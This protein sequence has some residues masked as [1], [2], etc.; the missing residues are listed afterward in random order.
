MAFQ[1]RNVICDYSLG[2]PNQVNMKVYE[3][4]CTVPTLHIFGITEEGRKA[5][6]HV[7]GVLPYLF[8][9]VGGTF[10]PYIETLM[11]TKLNRLLQRELSEKN[12]KPG[13]SYN[14]N[15]VFKMEEVE[16]KS[17]YGYY[18]EPESYAKVYFTNPY[19][20]IK[21]SKALGK[22]LQA[23]P[24]LQPYESHIPYTL[25]FFIDYSLFG[26]DVIHF[27]KVLYRI[28]P[29]RLGSEV[30]HENLTAVEIRNSEALSP[31]APIT[32][33]WIECDAYASDI[34]NSQMYKTNKYS[35]NPGLEYLWSEEAVRC[36]LQNRE[37]KDTFNTYTPRPYF[38]TRQERELKKRMKDVARGLKKNLADS[39]S[40]STTSS[41]T[42]TQM[43]N[44]TVAP[45]MDMTFSE[46]MRAETLWSTQ[47]S[48]NLP[49]GEEDE[50]DILPKEDE[51]TEE[52]AEEEISDMTM[53]AALEDK[54]TANY[55]SQRSVRSILPEENENVQREWL[56]V[57]E[58]LPLKVK[59]EV[60]SQKSQSSDTISKTMTNKSIH[61][62]MLFSE[63]FLDRTSLETTQAPDVKVVSDGDIA[64]VAHFSVAS[65]EII[66]QSSHEYPNPFSDPIIGVSICVI[67]DV[68]RSL[69]SSEHV[70]ITTISPDLL[71]DDRCFWVEDEKQ[72]FEKV[73]EIIHKCDPEMLLGYDTDRLSWGYLLRRGEVIGI[74]G[75]IKKLARY[76][77][78]STSWKVNESDVTSPDGRIL[79]T[80]WKVVRWDLA[81]R[82]YDRC[83]AALEVLKTKV[84]N[85]A[86]N[87]LCE[88]VEQFDK[89]LTKFVV[90][91]LLR[92]SFVDIH[93]LSEMDWF[94]RNAEMARV[95][96]IQL[97]E[98]WNRGSQ[99]RVES[100]LLR[101]A[102]TLGYVAPAISP[103]Q[104]TQMSAPEQ[105]Q[106]ILEP[107]S[108]VYHDPV[109]VL[110]F[111]SLYPSMIIAYNYCFST[112]MGKVDHL[113]LSTS[114]SEKTLELGAMKYDVN[115]LTIVETVAS[116]QFRCSPLSASFVT[117]E[118]RDGLIP[119]MLREVLGARIMIKN[120]MKLAKSRRLRRILD[121]RQLALKLV[122]NVTYGYTAANWSGRMPCPELADAILGKGRETLER[123]IAQV[124]K[125]NY[126]TSQVIYGDTDSMFVLVPGGTLEEAFEIGR[127]IAADVTNANPC[128]VT[129][130]LEKVYMGCVLETKKRYAGWMFESET[131][132]GRLDSKGIETIR[133]D[134]CPIVSKILSKSLELI[135]Q[136]RW[137]SLNIYLDSK[138]SRLDDL[139]FHNFTFSKE[140]RG[141]Y[142]LG[143][144][145]PQKKIAEALLEKNPV[146]VTL[147]GER[148]SYVIVEG[149]PDATVISC[150]RSLT[151]FLDNP[152]LKIHVS[153][154]VRAHI[155]A[156]L[157][158][159][160]D[161]IPLQIIWHQNKPRHCYTPECWTIGRRPWCT[162]C[163][164]QAYPY[165][166]AQLSVGRNER[167]LSIA[168]V[169]C[170]SCNQLGPG[171]KWKIES[172]TNFHCPVRQVIA[173]VARSEASNTLAQHSFSKQSRQ[174]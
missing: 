127:R 68:C 15:F 167:L 55:L 166:Y 162:S 140:Y 148:V 85:F 171:H 138:L 168:Q 62:K 2:P 3:S 7:H 41:G 107:V 63:S 135:F 161:L 33:C 48:P 8:L 89:R 60:P 58:D 133:R 49:I 93:I 125:G 106:L 147:P 116:R 99:F 25:Q 61:N 119:I 46:D 4:N 92:I 72:I 115:P 39:A 69:K 95:Y 159:V 105:L 45:N 170:K 129:L 144:P 35:T 21:L 120:S 87:I 163:S 118:A 40:Q 76:F 67:P 59:S 77:N 38:T 122:A 9:R 114:T 32:S 111:Q 90:G 88:M 52:Q 173:N 113:E 34:M 82:T 149:H 143:A 104:R 108:K 70:F 26:M 66:A 50:D 158:R 142:S 94:L 103:A 124:A 86:N 44:D 81:L 150:V 96:G 145:V 71:P 136:K 174:C 153:Y 31:L 23:V 98:V 169:A 83:A 100:M 6:V 19:Y 157:R 137:N 78:E 156:A 130:K 154:Y 20:V 141:Q 29:H 139:S 42:Y 47:D 22:E 43:L 1:M 128:P 13:R 121:A 73:I 79:T 134:T 101:L 131:D 64:E 53:L 36:R 160:T 123:A 16:R 74:P 17:L 54:E 155:L 37:L 11:K 12:K 132:T 65:L 112:I 51:I 91:Y 97:S 165:V 27:D 24:G 164:N 5:C 28:S 172:C 151:E 56:T 84:P 146:H 102:H 75:F 30:I 126:G 80:V 152:Q 14:Q 10:T 18:K 109:I 117:K 57:D 110:D